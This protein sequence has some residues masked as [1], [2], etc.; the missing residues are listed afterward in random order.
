[1]ARA[2]RRLGLL[3]QD[4]LEIELAYFSEQRFAVRLQV[5]DVVP[6][7]SLHGGAAFPIAADPRHPRRQV[8]SPA[9]RRTARRRSAVKISGNAV[10]YHK[11]LRDVKERCDSGTEDEFFSLS[12]RNSNAYIVPWGTRSKGSRCSLLI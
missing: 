7:E 6:A 5:L 1:V 10:A 11:P 9:V 2:I 12:G 3:C 8:R 4:T